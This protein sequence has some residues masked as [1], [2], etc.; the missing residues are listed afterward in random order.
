MSAE[1][2]ASAMIEKGGIC[3]FAH[4][5]P[6]GCWAHEQQHKSLQALGP[7]RGP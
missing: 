4:W 3:K 2:A 6:V 5:L 1:S 7:A